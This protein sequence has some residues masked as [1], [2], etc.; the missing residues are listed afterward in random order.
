[1]N[2][3]IHN[4]TLTATG[5]ATI[6]ISAD[7]ANITKYPASILKTMATIE[8]EDLTGRRWEAMAALNNDAADP[9]TFTVYLNER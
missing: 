3:T 4:F 7:D 6:T 8:A 5:R 2:I 9:H 1:M